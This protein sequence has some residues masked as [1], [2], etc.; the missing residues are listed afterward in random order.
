[1]K[2]LPKDVAALNNLARL[3]DVEAPVIGMLGET[4]RLHQELL[5][6]MVIQR[7]LTLSAFSD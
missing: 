1:M 2:S 3:R 6:E 5:A 7:G 4:N